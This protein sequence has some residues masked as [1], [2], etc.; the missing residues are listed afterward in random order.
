MSSP[1]QRIA[2]NLRGMSRIS[3]QVSQAETEK[4]KVVKNRPG[5]Y[6]KMSQISRENADILDEWAS[7]DETM[8]GHSEEDIEALVTIARRSANISTLLGVDGRTLEILTHDDP[9]YV[10][11]VLLRATD[12]ARREAISRMPVE[13]RTKWIR[14]LGGIGLIQLEEKRKEIFARWVAFVENLPDNVLT[15]EE[16]KQ[17]T[18][19]LEDA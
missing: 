13:E 12:D 16:K 9:E 19:P 2:E 14:R 17:F 6:R 11:G 18:T 8:A 5:L 10:L 1:L 4:Q 7:E 3:L 15:D